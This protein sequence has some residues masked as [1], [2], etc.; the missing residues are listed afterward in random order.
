MQVQLQN[1]KEN[2]KF[3]KIVVFKRNEI[4]ASENMLLVCDLDILYKKYTGWG[5]HRLTFL[6]FF[7]VIF[8]AFLQL[9]FYC[10]L[11][12]TYVLYEF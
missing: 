8:V 4:Y 2:G 10:V 9:Y 11:Y 5:W 6:F 7:S 3:L 12:Y 1:T